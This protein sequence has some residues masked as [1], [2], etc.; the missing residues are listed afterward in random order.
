MAD[1]T[2][3]RGFISQFIA[4]VPGR[5]R[6][7]FEEEQL[8]TN[9]G[10]M[11]G[12]AVYIVVV[13]II[14]QVVNAVLPQHSVVILM[15]YM[16]DFN[17]LPYYI[18]LSLLSLL[19]GVIYWIL[20][21]RARRG[22]IKSR[23]AKLW[24][25]QSL[26][27]IYAVIQLAF[28]TVNVFTQQGVNSYIMLALMIGMIPILSPKQ[29]ITTIFLAFLYTIGSVFFTQDIKDIAGLSSW[30]KLV[31]TDMRANLIIITLITMFISVSIYNL[32]V[33]NFLRKIALENQNNNLEATVAERTKELEEKTIAAEAASRAKSQFLTS[34]S[35]E[36][37]T[38]LNAIIGMTQIAKKA[39]SKAKAET[40]ID[41]IS[42]ASDHL[43]GILND[44]LDMSNIESGQ[45]RVEADRFV[46]RRAMHEVASIIG[47]RCAK[48]ALRFTHNV[49]ILPETAVIGDKLRLKQVLINLLGNAEK[50]TPEDGQI[51]FNV[52]VQADTADYIT[53]TF[54]V[55]D[56][57]VGIAEEQLPGLFT[58]FAQGSAAG[59]KNS[60]TG[61]GL[62]ISQ[63]LVRMMG[64]EITVES[65]LGSGSVF[66]FTL[67]LDKAVNARDDDEFS[68]P[69][70]SGKHI[71]VVED[72]EINRL[73]LAEL[74]EET[75]AQIDEAVDGA[76]AVEKFKASPEGF[77]HF[78]F[79]DLLMPNLNGN[80]A[81]RALRAL[82]R[83]DAQKIPIVALSANAY[84]EDVDQALA[85]GMNSHLAKPIDFVNVMRLLT[86]TLT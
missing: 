10:R 11:Y 52:T 1:S 43:L 72:I 75:H 54:A 38:P 41:E 67:R 66:T 20:L 19:V 29:S 64:G 2:S 9:L 62:A 59:M 17:S 23:N 86:E 3:R 57:G 44:I 15:G 25:V 14:L 82:P 49:E 78:V 60:G 61:L 71:L 85:A 5:Y 70:L 32:Y 6:S 84:L 53:V 81:T 63:N 56:N 36:I 27:Y 8:E 48:K 51:D 26:L 77:Y 35:H 21:A 22:K 13:Q 7:R 65:A 4:A 42:G 33:A 39:E 31:F 83:E 55:K 45:L 40:S 80:E 28:S 30:D 37:R 34:M 68:V 79:M 73:V 24:L 46:L 76:E 18:V 74:L 12:L 58:A 47:V 69:D 50:F 16:S